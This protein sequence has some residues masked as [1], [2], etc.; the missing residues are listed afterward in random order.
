MHNIIHHLLEVK[1]VFYCFCDKTYVVFATFG[2]FWGLRGF[3]FPENLLYWKK[4]QVL[5]EAFIPNS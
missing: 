1:R 3:F 5:R 4:T 2:P